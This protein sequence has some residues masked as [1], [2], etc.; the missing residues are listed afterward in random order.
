MSLLK[1]GVQEA[2]DWVNWGQ[3]GL[4]R[5]ADGGGRARATARWAW[6]QLGPV[7]EERLDGKFLLLADGGVGGQHRGGRDNWKWAW[8]WSRAGRSRRRLSPII[9][10]SKLCKNTYNNL[11]VEHLNIFISMNNS[12][13][14]Y[15]LVLFFI[16]S[17]IFLY[18]FHFFFH[19]FSVVFILFFIIIF[20]YFFNFFMYFLYFLYIYKK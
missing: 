16:F 13:C 8:L 1:A 7:A 19:D 11:V 4:Q 15:F 10:E 5:G 20:L 6:R 18:F 17:W 14:Y 9:S 3:V 12:R 2:A